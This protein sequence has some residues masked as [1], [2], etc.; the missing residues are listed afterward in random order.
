MK[1]L[2]ICCTWN[3]AE[4]FLRS[5]TTAA[6]FCDELVI[7]EGCHSGRYDQ[8]STDETVRYAEHLTGAYPNIYPAPEFAREGRY[9]HVQ[10]YVR[11]EIL[12]ASRLYKPGNWVFHADDDVFLFEDKIPMIKNVLE[13]TTADIVYLCGR[14]FLFNFRIH[15]IEHAV[16]FDR[17]TPGCFIKPPGHMCYA[18]GQKYKDGGKTGNLNVDFLYHH[19]VYVKTPERARARWAMSFEK[20]CQPSVDYLYDKFMAVDISTDEA[21]KENGSWIREIAGYQN[22]PFLYDGRHPEAVEGHPWRHID[23]CRV[24][25]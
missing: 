12:Q 24:L 25:S 19:Y 23:D 13:T 22:G 5:A 15:V 17:I 6:E 1:I 2:G 4:F 8:R 16:R 9:D 20:G 21:V 18:S 11:N 14:R 7:S 3:N 10:G